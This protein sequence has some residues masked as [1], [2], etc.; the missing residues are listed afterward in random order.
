MEDNLIFTPP[1]SI[2]V[3]GFGKGTESGIRNVSEYGYDAVSAYMAES[4][5]SI[6]PTDSSRLAIMCVDSQDDIAMQ[7]SKSFYDANVLTVIITTRPTEFEHTDYDSKTVVSLDQMESVVKN[8]LDPLFLPGMICFTFNDLETTLRNS[9]HFYVRDVIVKRSG[10]RIATAL[11]TLGKSISESLLNAAK[12]ISLILYYNP[13][14]ETPLKIKE[15]LPLN[16][17]I[18]KMPETT[19]V[20]WA[21]S[22]DCRLTA[23]SIRLSAIIS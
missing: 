21:L 6:Q 12:N 22:R 11:N 16:D 18:E 8:L 19:D 20:I 1:V 23:N 10:K 14:S 7:I 3:I 17:F 15:L 2:H 13:Q 5:Q 9:C 4:V